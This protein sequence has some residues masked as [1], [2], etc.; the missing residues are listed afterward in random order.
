MTGKMVIKPRFEKVSDFS[1]GL[2]KAMLGGKTAYIDKTG[3][4]QFTVPYAYDEMS[5]FKDGRA[6]YREKWGKI[7]TEWFLN[8]KGKKIPIPYR[9]FFIVGGKNYKMSL[10]DWQGKVL[11]KNVDFIGDFIDG[12]AYVYLKNNKGGYI[13]IRGEFVIPPKFEYVNEFSDGRAKVTLNGKDGFIDKKGNW[14]I[15]PKYD[16]I[17]FPVYVR[18]AV[19]GDDELKI[20]VTPNIYRVQVGGKFGYISKNGDMVIPPTFDFSRPFY[21]GLALARKGRQKGYINTR[22]KFLFE[23]PFEILGDFTGELAV[24]GENTETTQ[25]FGLI[26]RKGE[27]VFKPMFAEISY[28]QRQLWLVEIGGKKGL[29]DAGGNFIVKPQ[30][31]KLGYFCDGL[32]WVEKDKKISFINRSGKVVIRSKYSKTRSFSECLAAVSVYVDEKK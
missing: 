24:V 15:Q 3:K 13:N 9:Y 6:V 8:K 14:L 7:V 27:V 5:S 22:G 16:E 4:V 20:L 32:A 23:P 19:V 29:V 10:R 28:W 31:D 17:L 30:Y 21:G 12:L 18:Y 25:K 11:V 2:A 26:N 1:D